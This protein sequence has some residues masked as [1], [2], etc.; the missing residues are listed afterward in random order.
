MN[1]PDWAGPLDEARRCAEAYLAG[2]PDRPVR[3]AAGLP[4]LR[5]ALGG[6]VP[7]RPTDPREVIAALAGAAEPGVVA[8]GSGRYF[9]FVIG[10]AAAMRISVSN[11]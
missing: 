3:A 7:E 8:T 9:G 1:R 11:W 6:P 10:G 5:A 4:E 2:L